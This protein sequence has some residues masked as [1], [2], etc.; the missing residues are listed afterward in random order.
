MSKATDL[1]KRSTGEMVVAVKRG[2]VPI[3]GGLG[4]IW[5]VSVANWVAFG[6][7]LNTFGVQ[8]WS[9]S[10][11]W[12]VFTAPFLHGDLAHL[13]ANT[14]GFL[15]LA[16]LTML[17]KRMDFY[18][19]TVAGMLSSGLMSWVFGGIGTTHIG[20]S[21]VIFA[22]LG[23]L[24]ARGIFQRSWGTLALSAFIFWMFSGLLWGLFPVLAGVGI[25]WQGHLGGFLGG[26]LVARLLG[27]RIRE[28]DAPKRLR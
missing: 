15:M 28:K 26:V 6:G 1:V 23:F 13:L 14:T 12:H 3:V 21:G 9:I 7:A 19:V 17:R 11:V 27:S 24:M 18:V 22:Y 8:P 16:P 25:S 10:S 20:V 2:A 4:A 5:T